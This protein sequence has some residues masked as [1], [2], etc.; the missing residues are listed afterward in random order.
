MAHARRHFANAIKVIGKGN[1]KAI[2]SSIAYQTLVRIRAIYE[3][4]RPRKT[5]LR[6]N[7]CGSVRHRSDHWLRSI[8]L[9]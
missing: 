7:G 3:L 2:R 6:K 8:L 4:E 5:C 9:G 1:E